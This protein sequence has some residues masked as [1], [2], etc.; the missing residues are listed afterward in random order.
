MQGRCPG[1]T[2]GH[3]PRFLLSRLHARLFAMEPSD[4]TE[5]GSFCSQHHCHRSIIIGLSTAKRIRHKEGCSFS[6]T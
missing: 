3:V 5:D 4:L 2:R 1:I 6:K